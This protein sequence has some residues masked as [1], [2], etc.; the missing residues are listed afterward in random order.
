MKNMTLDLIA[1]ACNGAYHGA[2]DKKDVCVSGITIDSRKI[3]EGFLF[4]AMRGERGIRLL[5]EPMIKVQ[6]HV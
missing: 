5:Q 2:E 1:K 4:V 3:E 6:Q